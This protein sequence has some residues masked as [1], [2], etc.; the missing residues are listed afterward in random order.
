MWSTTVG[1]PNVNFC[2]E[3]KYLTFTSLRMRGVG[4]SGAKE[5]ASKSWLLYK[6]SPDPNP[7]YNLT[8]TI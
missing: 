6:P 4:K 1:I 8:A 5:H 7:N 2:I 3:Y